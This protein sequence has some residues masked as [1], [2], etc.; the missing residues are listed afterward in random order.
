MP[1]AAL[2]SCLMVT[3]PS[4]GRLAFVK[5]SIAAYCA[6]THAPRE[7]V[8]VLDQG[9]AEARAAIAGHVASLGRDDI[10][11]VAAPGPMTL[12]AL[13]NLSRESA[14]GVVHCQWDDDDLHHPE[15]VERQ[16]A[17]L[18]EGGAEAVCLQEVMLYFAATRELYWTNWRAAEPTVMP[19]TLMCRAAAPVRY[20][21]TGETAR[22]GED[23]AVCLQLLARG[24]LR[25]IT[26]APQLLVY[27]NHGANTWNDDFHRMLAERLGLSQGLLR[28]REARIREMLA[29]VD[30]GPGAV[31]VRGPNGAA[32]SLGD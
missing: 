2:V 16:L 3:L 13:R 15:R 23:T 19:A 26:D 29:G 28:R 27:V 25:P 20:P 18:D 7:L 5:R 9:P 8:M 30:F 31:T 4:A 12:G 1:D 6:Q 32:F 17:A 11:I 24:G 10:R 22:R 21:E 14:R